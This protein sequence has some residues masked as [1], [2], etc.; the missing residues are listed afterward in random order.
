[1]QPTRRARAKNVTR[2]RITGAKVPKTDARQQFYLKTQFKAT[3]PCPKQQ[4]TVPRSQRIWRRTVVQTKPKIKTRIPKLFRMDRHTGLPVDYERTVN[5]VMHYVNP[6]L[7]NPPSAEKVL[8]HLLTKMLTEVVRQGGHC[9]QDTTQLCSLLKNSCQCHRS[10]Q[11]RTKEEKERREANE[12]LSQFH[13]AC[14][15]GPCR[16]PR[17]KLGPTYMSKFN[18]NQLR[19]KSS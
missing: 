18:F 17:P 14:K 16:V 9:W 6:H 3:R 12:S 19:I 7:H 8:E 11:L 2:K 1:M 13:S 5:Q 15:R 4:S 10:S